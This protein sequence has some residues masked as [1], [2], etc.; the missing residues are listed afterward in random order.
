[1]H[2]EEGRFFI[3]ETEN[4]SRQIERNAREAPQPKID[5]ALI[6][7]LTGILQP[8]RRNAYQEVRVIPKFDELKLSGHRVLIVIKPDGKIPPSKLQNF[9]EYQQEKNNLLV[10]TGQDSHLTDAVEDRL[11]EL[12]A[13]EHISKRLNPKDT[14]YEDA[15]DRLEESK[16]RFEK[17]LSAAYNRIYFPSVDDIDSRELLVSVTIDNGLMLGN[18]DQSAEAQIETIL[19]SPRS[20]Y[21]LALDIQDGFSQ[22]FAM[23][24]EYLWPSGKE[25]RRAPWRDI[26][27]RAKCNPSW[28]WIPG[29]NGMEKLKAEALKQGRWRLGEDGYIE[30]GPFPKDK[31][32]ANISL[33][34]TDSETGN[35]TL[36]IT[37][38]HA[39]ESPVVYYSTKSD[40]IKSFT[41]VTNL[42][43]FTTSEGTLYFL[44]KD[45]TGHYE[46]AGPIRWLADLKIRHKIEPAADKRK[47]TLQ[48]TPKA[49]VFYTLDGSNPKDGI[50]YKDAFEIGSQATRLLIYAQSGEAEET[51]NFQIPASSD[52]TVQIDEIKAARIIQRISLD[53]TDK[54]YGIVN[55]FRDQPNIRFKGVRIEIGSA[56]NTV[57]VRFHEREITARMIEGVVSSLRD[58][59]HENQAPVAITISDCILFDTGLEAKEFAKIVG[60]ELRPDNIVQE[61]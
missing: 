7:R 12:Y 27:S 6:N 33:V 57:T 31:S 18:E 30:K 25:N 24:E 42:D 44:V 10:L 5:Q 11:R 9:F 17:A 40:N 59:L 50:L 13:I 61:Q 46:S 60:L 8:E 43:N 34:G 39:G 3:K 51:A 4:L 23:A 54:V 53:S 32:T 38:L 41:Q 37:P 16:G 21:K 2:R 15:R 29:K 1:M 20:S 19:A 35:A 49:D 22:Y 28:P 52:K 58:V 47:I 14:L 48:C 26:V 55:R 36:S 45:T 56:E